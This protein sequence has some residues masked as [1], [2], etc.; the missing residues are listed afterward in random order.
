MIRVTPS[1]TIDE[2]EIKMTFI[3]SSGPGGQNVN[4]VATAVQMRFDVSN[5][6]ALPPDVRKRMIR[7]AGKRITEKGVLILTARRFRTQEQNRH[8]AFKRLIALIRT[9]AEKPKLRRRTKP[10][11]I[12]KV[13]RLETKLQR[14]KIKRLR[15]AV[16]AID[17]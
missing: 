11:I 2:N 15:K 16:S 5:S 4:K 1:I 3:C 12:S 8:D 6:P 17:E 13:K 7:L 10:T 14:G 9:A